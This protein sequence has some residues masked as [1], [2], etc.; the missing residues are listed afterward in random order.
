MTGREPEPAA[1][2]KQPQVTGISTHVLDMVRGTP[3]RDVTVQ[4]ERC[5]GSGQ[6]RIVGSGCTGEDGRCGQLLSQ[7]EELS[8]G[9]YRLAF[10]AAS[11]YARQGVHGLYPTVQVIFSVRDGEMHFHLPLLLSPYGYTTYRGR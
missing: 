10:D 11:Y 5:E 2:S 7:G 3:A 6:W 9:T 1:Q 4:L 8:P